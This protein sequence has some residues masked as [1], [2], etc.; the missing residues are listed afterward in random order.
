MR[1]IKV[2]GLIA[3][4]VTAV[5]V[6]AINVNVAFQGKGLSD[7]ALANVEVLARGETAAKDCWMTITTKAGHTVKYCGNDCNP[8]GGVATLTST[9]CN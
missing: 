7:L 8:S 6:A 5:V 3:L 4:V 2:G 9:K 1:K